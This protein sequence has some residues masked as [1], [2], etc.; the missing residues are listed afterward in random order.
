MSR[1]RFTVVLSQG[2]GKNPAK[3][4]LEESVAAALILEPGLDVC[5]VPHKCSEF[6]ES[7][8]PIKLWEYLAAGKPVVSTNVAGFRDYPGLCRIAS[9]KNQRRHIFQFLGLDRHVRADL[10]EPADDDPV[11]FGQTAGDDALA[12]TL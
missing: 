5:I 1:Q 9:G 8:N 4:S 2:Q 11:V 3:R 12:V 10:L 7:L 6:V